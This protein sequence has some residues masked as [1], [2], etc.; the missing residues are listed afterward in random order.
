MGGFTMFRGGGNTLQNAPYLYGYTGNRA[1]GIFSDWSEYTFSGDVDINGIVCDTGL[2]RGIGMY[3]Q[4]T[5]TLDDGVSIKVSGL[6]AGQQ[7]YNEETSNFTKPYNPSI[8][9]PF[10]IMWT[11][12]DNFTVNTENDVLKTFNSSIVGAENAEISVSCIY[13]RDGKDDSDW[14]YSADNSDCASWEEAIAVAAAE[15][16]AAKDHTISSQHSINLYKTKWTL[17]MVI[18]IVMLF[19][20]WS[21]NR[22]SKDKL[23]ESPATETA[24]LLL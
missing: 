18:V 16:L 21:L 10:H 15:T 24:P 12:S 14:D 13:G 2:V 11:D 22:Y 1:H 8:A 20:G 6:S 7:L 9:K 23:S 17:T 4:T 19:G 5:L 3:R